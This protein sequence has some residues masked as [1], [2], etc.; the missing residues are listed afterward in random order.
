MN[1]EL[2]CSSN[3]IPPLMSVGGSGEWAVLSGAEGKQ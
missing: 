3:Y 2:I 1:S